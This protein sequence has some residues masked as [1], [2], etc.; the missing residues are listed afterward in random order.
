MW[1]VRLAQLMVIVACWPLLGAGDG[2]ESADIWRQDKGPTKVDVSSYP[3]EAQKGYQILLDNCGA[4][5][6]VARPLNTSMQV[7]YWALY[8]GNMKK[9]H[10]VELTLEESRKLVKFLMLD[11]EKRKNATPKDFFPPFPLK[12]P[13]GDEAS[14]DKGGI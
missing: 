4:C 12:T 10:G 8:V 13:P 2:G 1:R 6:S 11:Q 9:R 14:L 5:H 3:H 7:E